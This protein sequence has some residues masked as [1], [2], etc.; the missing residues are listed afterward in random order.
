MIDRELYTN[1]LLAE[2]SLLNSCFSGKFLTISKCS[3]CEQLDFSTDD[4]LSLNLDVFNSG[5]VDHIKN[6]RKEYGGEVKEKKKGL[7]GLFKSISSKLLISDPF[8]SIKEVTIADYMNNL[9]NY[10]LIKKN[11]RLFM[12]T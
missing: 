4:F 10:S 1:Q 11:E 12:M 5:Q 8:T 3:K 6:I 7:S 2:D 9:L